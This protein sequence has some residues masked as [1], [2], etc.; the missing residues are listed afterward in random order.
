MCVLVHMCIYIRLYVCACVRVHRY[1]LVILLICIQCWIVCLI[2]N[3]NI[4]FIQNLKI[5]YS[6]HTKV[7]KNYW[8]CIRKNFFHWFIV[9]WQRDRYSLQKTLHTI[10]FIIVCYLIR[11]KQ[12]TLNL[13][14]D[15]CHVES[16]YFI[17]EIS[18][19]KPW[20]V[21]LKTLPYVFLCNL[22][23]KTSNSVKNGRYIDSAIISI[24]FSI[25]EL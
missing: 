6:L 25:S 24:S 12:K 19:L 17:L 1:V 20:S 3:Q 13:I 16:P 7:Y 14:N 10:F 21:T 22:M 4:L 15:S 2:R 8:F 18:T 5:I 23:K 11:T 9:K